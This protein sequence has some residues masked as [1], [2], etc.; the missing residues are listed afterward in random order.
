METCRSTPTL[1]AHVEGKEWQGEVYILQEVNVLPQ[2]YHQAATDGAVTRQ[3]CI[4][5]MLCCGV[6]CVVDPTYMPRAMQYL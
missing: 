4:L 6:K 5:P 3:F 1:P 2:Q